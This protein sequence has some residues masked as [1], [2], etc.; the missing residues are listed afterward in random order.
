MS[1]IVDK[2]GKLFEKMASA[3]GLDFRCDKSNRKYVELG[4]GNKFLTFKIWFKS[5]VTGRESFVKVQVNFVECLLFR[6]RKGRLNSLLQKKKLK[7]LELLFPK[8]LHFFLIT[9]NRFC[10]YLACIPRIWRFPSFAI[11]STY[12]M[13]WDR[14]VF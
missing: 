13:F 3:R 2:L 11:L 10:G 4:G 1:I 14:K 5:E 8:L 9:V 12:Y 7:E 6:P